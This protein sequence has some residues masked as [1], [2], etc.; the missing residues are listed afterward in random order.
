MWNKER[1][2]GSIKGA[3]NRTKVEIKILSNSNTPDDF[4]RL[5]QAEKKLD[6]L[7]EEEEGY[8]RLRSR[9]D[10]L[11]KGIETQNGFTL[12]PRTKRE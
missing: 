2:K 8:W 12:K 5:L 7:L 1:L 11:K 6:N 9:E 4:D 10:W 3:I